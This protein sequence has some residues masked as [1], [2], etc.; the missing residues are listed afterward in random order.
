MLGMFEQLSAIHS[1]SIDAAR[2]SQLQIEHLMHNHTRQTEQAISKYREALADQGWVNTER[3]E[4]R[5]GYGRTAANSFL[6]KLKKMGYV[7]SRPRF[8][9]ERYNKKQGWEWSWVEGK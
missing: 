7:K 4:W 9:A 2:R 6:R 1:S 5:L 8:G 3:L